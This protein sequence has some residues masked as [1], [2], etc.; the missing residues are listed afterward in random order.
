MLPP[1]LILRGA[2][3]QAF[4]IFR[5]KSSWRR[6][7]MSSQPPRR[8][9]NIF[10]CRRCRTEWM[11]RADCR[12]CTV[13]SAHCAQCVALRAN[14][15]QLSA[16]RCSGIFAG[17]YIAYG[18]VGLRHSAQ[19]DSSPSWKE[20]ELKATVQERPALSDETSTFLGRIHRY[21]ILIAIIK[22]FGRG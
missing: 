6:D 16:L 10:C 5:S 3:A 11:S 1:S 15:A 12:E 22:D 2:T 18:G 21:E 9:A 14:T 20:K 4:H 19:L 13:H 7:P 8:S 17:Q